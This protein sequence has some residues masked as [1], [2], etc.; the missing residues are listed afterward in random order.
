VRRPRA[1][2]PHQVQFGWAVGL[3]D[4][5]GSIGIYNNAVMLRVS[6]TDVSAIERFGSIVEAG[7]LSWNFRRESN[8]KHA[9]VWTLCR[10]TSIQYVLRDFLPFLV[11][12]RESALIAL[13]FMQ[14][15]RSVREKRELIK[16]LKE[17]M[18]RRRG[19]CR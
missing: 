4:G 18:I 13:R 7:K 17:L 10:R 14:P 16:A 2:N 9:L 11:T 3:F 12:K 19:R 6:M 5:E 1:L 15:G 8:R